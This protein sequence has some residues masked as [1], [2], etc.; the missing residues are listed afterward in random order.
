MAQQMRPEPMNASPNH[1]KVKTTLKFADAQFVAGSFIAGKMEMECKTDKGLG[2][3]IIMVELVATEELTSRDHS[4]TST[5]LHSKRIFQGPGLPP[6]N[7][8]N[9]FQEAGD[10]PLPPNY[11]PARK[12]T[13]SF[14]FRLPLPPTSPSSI[15]FGSGLANVRYEVR[16]SV[17]AS[18]KGDRR[19]VTDRKEVDVVEAYLPEYATEPEAVV[20]SENGKLWAH[21]K[22]VGGVLIAGEP[23]CVELHVK[24]HST[25]K[26][27]GLS[28]TL[29]RDLHLPNHPDGDKTPLQISDSL[30]SVSFKGKE[31]IINPGVEG[32][33]NLVFD[34]PV[35]AR[36]VKGG[37][38]HGDEEENR[39]TPALFEV[40][41]VA[42][43]KIAMG[44]GN[45]D[46]YVNIPVKVLHP[47]SVPDLPLPEP[48]P[49]P[50]ISPAQPYAIP[51]MTP[52][53]LHYIAPRTPAPY[54]NPASPAGLAMSPPPL[55]PQQIQSPVS[56][57]IYSPPPVQPY[58]VPPHMQ[59]V[60]FAP[61]SIPQHA[62]PIRP[63]SAEPVPTQ[64]MFSLP[65]GLP[66]SAVHQPPLL[67]LLADAGVHRRESSAGGEREE[68][69]GERASRISHHLRISSRHRSVSPQAHRYAL[70]AMPPA[71]DQPID[72]PVVVPAS[73][74]HLAPLPSPRET[75]PSLG[76]T[77][78]MHLDLPPSTTSPVISPRPLLSPKH[79]YTVDPF[80]RT[81]LTKSERVET[82]ERLAAEAEKENK[83]MS[84][85]VIDIKIALDHEKVNLD[86]DKDKTLPSP[87][88]PSGKTRA[89]SAMAE[90][91][92][93]I[94][95]LFPPAP[96]SQ[97]QKELSNPTSLVE[98]HDTPPTPT[99]AA[100]T[101]PHLGLP[102]VPSHGALTGLDALEARLL[103]EVGTRK[104]E[105]ND[106]R[107]D[108]RAVLPIAIPRRKDTVDQVNDSAISSLTLPGVG[109]DEM[110]INVGKTSPSHSAGGGLGVWHDGDRT[111][112]GR[113]VHSKQGKEK[114]SDPVSRGNAGSKSEK[115]SGR[116]H[117]GDDKGKDM[118]VHKLRKDAVSRVAAW[119][120]SVD[121]TN[122]PSPVPTPPITSPP[123]SPPPPDTLNIG[124]IV[125]SGPLESEAN[126]PADG[127][128]S[129][130]PQLPDAVPNPR[131]SGFVP[132]ETIRQRKAQAKAERKLPIFPPLSTANQDP[133]V[134][135]NIQSA[136]GGRGGKVTAVAALWTQQTGNQDQKVPPS[137]K[138]AKPTAVKPAGGVTTKPKPLIAP[139]PVLSQKVAAPAKTPPFKPAKPKPIVPTSK[140]PG[141][142]S[143][144]ATAMKSS[145]STVTST[146]QDV[147]NLSSKRAKMIKSTSVPAA[148]SSSL[149]T[150]MISSTASLARPSPSP[151]LGEWRKV[152]NELPP[153]QSR[154]DNDSTPKISPAKGEM[155]FGQ[156]RLRELIKRYQGQ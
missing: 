66:L 21:G 147:T 80:S 154:P 133:E 20:V 44:F 68:G 1:P 81:T 55:W 141:L 50:P 77:S 73:R 2:I 31:Y 118:E 99:L 149:A 150:P 98:A 112:R 117:R 38:R 43:V 105:T 65:S 39:Y 16:A 90:S 137:N 4:A 19:L 27:S 24:N 144:P 121:P 17:G 95:T 107:P 60:P 122:P 84:V 145:A 140:P 135:Y 58:Y 67:P 49:L 47:D 96:Q 92:P 32:V 79:S 29:L 126:G 110:E 132:I 101:S 109:A 87:P 14:L 91:R 104:V 129:V 42:S 62:I 26:N 78:P 5:F 59:V 72:G 69:Q 116:K 52:S 23:A 56:Y 48:Y 8:V 12:G 93:R 106:K 89:I 10:A 148:I 88:V 82:L 71:S 130:E 142:L 103:A 108:V 123:A 153:I 125:Q 113:S 114:E 138:V 41:C 75:Q 143:R 85:K 61:Y 102:R 22:L 131:S 63:A 64:Q 13:T 54:I 83:N 146:A 11:Y 128:I 51:S 57:S 40:R 36:G 15:N 34:V 28:V 119:L 100:V 6:S 35:N 97:E 94:D 139:K 120:G 25:K 70:P 156:A 53:P 74:T 151:R 37:T 124:K 152:V 115:K 127:V 18:W 155:A 76:A 46:I 30:T 136:R 3:G 111:E 33:A 9:T 45:K 7:A 134:R 86:A